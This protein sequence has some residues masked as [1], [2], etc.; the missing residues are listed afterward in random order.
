[1]RFSKRKSVFLHANLVNIQGLG[2]LILGKSGIGKSECCLELMNRGHRLIAD[3]VTQVTLQKKTLLNGQPA[4][5]LGTHM[6]IRGIGIID[7]QA[8][9]GGNRVMPSS[10][11]DLVVEL[12]E[13][14]AAASYNRIGRQQE[15]YVLLG[16]K[17]P[18]VRIP[19]SAA[20]NPATLIEVAAKNQCLKRQG[21]HSEKSFRERVTRATTANTSAQGI[22]KAL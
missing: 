14:D 20:R 1:M 21:L 2:V 8:I 11:I 3:D 7:A 17:R 5:L 18:L 22:G 6:E 16:I 9:F 19:V 10:P 4:K 15:S 13:W 12:L